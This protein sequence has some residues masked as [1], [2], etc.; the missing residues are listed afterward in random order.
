L[1]AAGSTWKTRRG[2]KD[3]VWVVRS[4]LWARRFV[5]Y[6]TVTAAAAAAAA[7]DDDDDNDDDDE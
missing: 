4:S 3:I 6:I 1:G 5:L 2:V 7:D